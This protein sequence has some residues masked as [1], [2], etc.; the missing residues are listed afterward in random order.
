M[1]KDLLA[2]KNQVASGT[3]KIYSLSLHGLEPSRIWSVL[4]RRLTAI[5]FGRAIYLAFKD[6]YVSRLLPQLTDS[7]FLVRF[8]GLKYE[9]VSSFTP[10]AT[11]LVCLVLLPFD[12]SF[13]SS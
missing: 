11:L 1:V 7:Q 8:K 4:T 12:C 5:S 3:N 6:L 10:L 2:F 13:Q 9:G